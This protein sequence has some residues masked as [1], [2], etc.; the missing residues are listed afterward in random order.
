MILWLG[1]FVW[2]FG[3]VTYK[4][5]RDLVSANSSLNTKLQKLENQTAP[6]CPTQ[7]PTA[8]VAARQY[9][10]NKQ[11]IKQDGNNN[12]ATQFSVGSQKTTGNGSPIVNGS[13]TA[14]TTK[15]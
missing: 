14:I 11:T 1:L 3:A 10:E 8:R 6:P 4:D 15:P 5:H 2:A 13:N 7:L 9:K 12:Q